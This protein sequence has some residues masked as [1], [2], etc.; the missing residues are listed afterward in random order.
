MRTRWW[1]LLIILGILL[2]AVSVTAAVWPWLR[3]WL[4]QPGL[5]EAWVR[6]L[7]VDLDIGRW[8]PVAALLLVGLIELVWAVNL[9]RRSSAAERHL[10]RLQRLHDRETEVLT[11]EIEL[12]KEERLSLRAELELREDLI[13]EE[14]ARLWTQF[15]DAQRATGLIPR[16]ASQAYD[17]A[18]PI[19]QTK[20][21]MPDLPEPSPE[22]RNR[23][24][25]II[26][27]L[28]RIEMVTSVSSRRNQTALQAQ[29]HADELMRL[30]AACYYLGQNERALPHFNAAVD[31]AATD[32]TALIDRAVVNMALTRYQPALQDLD[33]ALKLDERPW[34]HLYRGLIRE[35]QE[36]TRRALEDYTRAIR[37]DGDFGPALYRRGMLYAEM[38]EFE[39]AVQDQ[40]RVLDMDPHHVGALVARGAARIALG[41]AHWALDDLDQACSLAPGSALAFCQRGRARH[42]LGLHEEALVDFARAMDL[43]PRFAPAYMARGDTHVAMGEPDQAVADYG[44]VIAL[45]PKNAAAHYARGL[46]RGLMREHRAAIEDYDRALE[47]DPAMAQA[48]ASRGGAYEKMGDHPQAIEDLDRA[49]ALAPT[50]AMA[51]YTRGLV[52]GS[53]GEYDRASRDLNRAVELDP[54]LAEQEGNQG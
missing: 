35:H 38:G 9:A 37:M 29:Q 44:E 49:I 47:L 1:V 8:G 46:A 23:W 2:V 22:A 24:R 11:H 52:Y 4:P 40:S 16:H 7:V 14:K 39:K 3:G 30:G 31:S 12:L 21:I 42:R 45:D 34:A 36:E 50:L 48:L 10:R 54:A 20:E 13:R 43:D 5:L 53:L 41:D 27:Q 15:E 26:F 6:Y 18:P 19:L 33:R 25:Q 17:P 51:Y 28:E 32:P